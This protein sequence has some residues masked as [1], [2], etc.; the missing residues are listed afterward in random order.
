MPTSFC[1]ETLP[2][3]LSTSLR[4]VSQDKPKGPSSLLSM[5]FNIVARVN[6]DYQMLQRN[7]H[8][9]LRTHLRYIKLRVSHLQLLPKRLIDERR[10]LKR[11]AASLKR[12]SIVF[13]CRYMQ[14]IVVVE[15]WRG[16]GIVS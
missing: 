9:S 6:A 12:L 13:P 2:T 11:N 16:T 8:H 14:L 10:K 5:N 7:K 1:F 3:K 4:F 15:S